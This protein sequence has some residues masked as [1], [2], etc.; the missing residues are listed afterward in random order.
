MLRAAL[1][2]I[3]LL[4]FPGASQAQNVCLLFCQVGIFNCTLVFDADGSCSC[5]CQ[6]LDFLLNGSERGYLKSVP[7]AFEGIRRR[8]SLKELTHQ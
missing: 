2:V 6:T 5:K 8:F 4:A 3:G 1:I 7:H